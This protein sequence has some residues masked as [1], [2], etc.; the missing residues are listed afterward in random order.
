MLSLAERNHMAPP[1]PDVTAA[2]AAYRFTDLQSFLD[3]YY[4]GANVLRTEQD[5]YDLTWAYVTRAVQE[6]VRHVEPFFDP[7]THVDRGVPFGI[8]VAGILLALE[9]AEENF[10]ITSKLIMCFLR[11]L[12]ADSA[13]HTLQTAHLYRSKIAGVGLDSAEIGNPPEKFAGV[14]EMAGTAGFHRVAHAGEE[15][16]ASYITD[17][18]DL[19]GAERI[20]HGVRCLDDPTVVARLVRERVPLTVCPLSNVRLR[21]FDTMGAHPLKRMM[22]AGLLVTVNSDDPAY[23]GGYLVDNYL[24]VADALDLS[25]FDMVTLARNSFESSFADEKRKAACLGEIDAFLASH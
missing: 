19:L 25:P 24:A 17:A 14:F 11:D 23:F 2:R 15:G 10:G 1:Y 7:Q 22:D 12:P 13:E 5:F 16:P 8:V 18:L 6:N 3:L 21:V 9:D 20:D 4:Q